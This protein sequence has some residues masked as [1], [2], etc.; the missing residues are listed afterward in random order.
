MKFLAPAILGILLFSPISAN[1]QPATETDI[2]K[3]LPIFLADAENC[4]RDRKAC[5][6]VQRQK[7]KNTNGGYCLW[8]E[9]GGVLTMNVVIH[10]PGPHYVYLRC[11][12]NE[13][14]RAIRVQLGDLFQ[15]TG[16]RASNIFLRSQFLDHMPPYG[17]TGGVTWE[18]I[19]CFMDAPKNQAN[20]KEVWESG[21]LSIVFEMEL[22]KRLNLT[23]DFDSLWRRYVT[24]KPGSRYAAYC[25]FWQE[26]GWTPFQKFLLKLHESPNFKPVLTESSL[27][28]EL[29]LG[30][31]ADVS[32]FF[33]QR[34]WTVDEETSE[35]IKV[36]LKQE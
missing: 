8:V 19:Q 36:A 24:N 10:Q 9:S 4:I 7:K 17:A 15:N 27:V 16:F 6:K 34:G 11:P 29:S 12:A 25:E 1:A 32:A 33:I 3:D 30:A 35:K 21:V 31:N 20:W 28:Y 13:L 18:V 22:A 2:T 26:Y 5:R 14:E 23:W